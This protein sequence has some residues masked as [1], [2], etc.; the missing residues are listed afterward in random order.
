MSEVSALDADGALRAAVTARQVADRGEA[1]LLALA[2][3]WADLHAV[4]PGAD[5]D[6]AGFRLDG[7]TSRGVGGAERLGWLAGDGTPQVA[8]FA[9]GELAA[10]LGISS[11]AGSLLVG[12]ALE[13]RHRLPRLWARV[14]AGQLQA[15]RAR[16]IAAHTKDLSREAVG[17]VDAQLAPIAHKIGL[18]RVLTL[19]DVAVRRFDPET[20]ARNERDRAEGRGVWV[21]EQMTDAT[22][23]VR[24]EADALDVQLFDHTLNRIAEGLARLGDPDRLDLRRAK[25]VGVI[26]DPQGT[27][28]LL[29]ADQPNQPDQVDQADQADQPADRDRPGDHGA[30]VRRSPVPGSRSRPQVTL[31]IHLSEAAV[32][33]RWGTARVEDLGPATLE[34][35][36]TWLHRADL[37]VRPVLDLDD[38]TSVDGYETPTEMR[39]TVLLRNPCCP[40]PW[41]NNLT[42]RKDMDHV[43]PYRDPDEGGPPGQ[44]GAHLLCSPCRRHHRYRTHGGW[45]YTMPDPGLYLWRSPTGRR[46]LVDHTGTT[47]LDQT[48]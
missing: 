25:A 33:A 42:R 12:D 4:L 23:E 7:F 13:L 26:A 15:W 48:A 43:I 37:T 34:T 18:Q 17:F 30:R 24:I 6:A 29:H 47:N 20:A 38:R 28:D 21:S 3:H 14:Q 10:A 9:P 39:E 35:V 36:A 8:E 11:H 40:F 32:T 22:L 41:C 19:L 44:T 46:Y 5:V 1:D 31:Y 27:L 2:A 16:Q 45:T